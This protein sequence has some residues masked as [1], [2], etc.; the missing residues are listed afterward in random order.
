MEQLQKPA[1]SFQIYGDYVASE[2]REMSE[3]SR[4]KS[5]L[6]ISWILLKY[7]ED[8]SLPST[9][10]VEVEPP[11]QRIPHALKHIKKLTNNDAMRAKNYYENSEDWLEPTNDELQ[12]ESQSL[13]SKIKITLPNR[14]LY[15][16]TDA[17]EG[18]P[19]GEQSN[20]QIYEAADVEVIDETEDET[21]SSL[22]NMDN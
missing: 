5:K 7:A 17:T 15:Q 11:Q 14:T 22:C 3:R 4:K 13:L 21:Q 2:L 9:S 10:S 18:L 8:E 6:E 20:I 16:L 19:Y 12:S 1:D